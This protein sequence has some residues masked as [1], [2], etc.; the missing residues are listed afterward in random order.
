MLDRKQDSEEA[1]TAQNKFRS[2]AYVSKVGSC[3]PFVLT[4]SRALSLAWMLTYI[5]KH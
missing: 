1:K 3:N 2:R 4:S 5:S